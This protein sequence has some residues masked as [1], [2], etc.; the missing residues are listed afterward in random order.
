[1]LAK[2]CCCRGVMEFGCSISEAVELL[3]ADGIPSEDMHLLRVRAR[4]VAP[5]GQELTDAHPSDAHCNEVFDGHLVGGVR[6][7]PELPTFEESSSLLP[8]SGKRP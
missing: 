8:H 4:G 1:M 2:V 3:R 6:M 5:S 7:P